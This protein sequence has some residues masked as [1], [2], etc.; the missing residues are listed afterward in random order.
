MVKFNSHAKQK[1]G[2]KVGS[3]NVMKGNASPH[4]D[5][6]DKAVIIMLIAVVVISLLSL[7]LYIYTSAQDTPDIAAG[8]AIAQEAPSQGIISLEIVPPPQPAPIVDTYD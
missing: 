6:S 1:V 3:L 4:S 2:S 8:Q 5:V 7:G